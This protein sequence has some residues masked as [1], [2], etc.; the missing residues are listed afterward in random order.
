VELGIH[1]EGFDFLGCRF[2][3]IR[4]HF[5]QRT[6]GNYFRTGNASRQFCSIDRY[7]W[8]RLLRLKQRRG[9]NRKRPINPREWL[10]QRFVAELGL[11]QL[12]GTIRYPGG[13]H[14]A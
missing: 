1:K 7:V 4:S 13:V 8:E 3:K 5:K 2:Q 12:L 9:G 14:A 10:H 6:W 11:H